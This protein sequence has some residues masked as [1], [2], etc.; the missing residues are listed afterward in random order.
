VCVE[1]RAADVVLHTEGHE[2]HLRLHVVR[3]LPGGVQRDRFPDPHDVLL[4]QAVP[5]EEGAGGVRPV[6]LEALVLRAM[7][8]EQADIV[9][10]RADVEQLG[11]VADAESL[12][13]HRCPKE[14]TP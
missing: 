10:H 2:S 9:E 13:L 7:A 8:L 14:H 5:L 6:D 4:G 3:H 12:G 1:T 11:V